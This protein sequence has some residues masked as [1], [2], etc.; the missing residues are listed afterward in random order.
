MQE[1]SI[2]VVNVLYYFFT[3]VFHQECKLYL[4]EELFGPVNFVCC[5]SIAHAAC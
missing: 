5:I 4:K 2:I 3:S 1:Y